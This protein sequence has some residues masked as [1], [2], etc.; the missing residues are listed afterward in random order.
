MR[1]LLLLGLLVGARALKL[2][3]IG[4]GDP[5]LSLCTAKIA[6]GQ[7]MTAACVTRKTETAQKMLWGKDATDAPIELVDGAENIGVALKDA[8]ALVING[9]AFGGLKPNFAA[10][11]LNNAPSLKTV[12]VCVDA[13]ESKEA[14]DATLAAC[15]ERSIGANVI[16]VGK[17]RGGGPAAEGT[18]G[19]ADTL[20]SFFYDTNPDLL[21]FMGDQYADGYL[22][23]LKA[24]AGDKPANFFQKIAASQ[25]NGAAPGVSC[26]VSA[27][28]ALV[29]SLGGAG[30]D[31]T[32]TAEE[33]TAA[34]QVSDF[35]S[36]FA[37]AS[38]KG[39]AVATGPIKS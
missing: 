36:F 11:A 29:A 16:R 25:A 7:G 8:D 3:V 39:V 5:W 37:E 9:A 22:L 30:V 33:G 1:V 2:V 38:E 23:G 27:A 21:G 4:P 31:L 20:A 6:H 24:E 13:G 34:A 17:L 15:A 19:A 14:V 10:A 32:L 26:R 28:A 35:P 12:S 18:D